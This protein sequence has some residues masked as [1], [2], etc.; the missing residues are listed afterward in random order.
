M[1]AIHESPVFK[2]DGKSF[3]VGRGRWMDKQIVWRLE[4]PRTKHLELILETKRWTLSDRGGGGKL[5]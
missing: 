1:V 5:L 4:T 3:L 2:Q